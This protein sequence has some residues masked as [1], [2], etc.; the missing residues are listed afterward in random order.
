MQD[1]NTPPEETNAA[2]QETEGALDG[3]TCSGSSVPQSPV[4]DEQGVVSPEVVEAF[5]QGRLRIIETHETKVADEIH[6]GMEL[7]IT[8]M[9]GPVKFRVTEMDPDAGSARAM[10]G[11]MFAILKRR[12]DGW[13]DQHIHGNADG[14]LRV[15]FV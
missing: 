14:V 5:R 9:F 3:A 13:Y 2:K 11:R 12:E 10:S 1:E 6:S 8:T 15:K 4:D 7:S